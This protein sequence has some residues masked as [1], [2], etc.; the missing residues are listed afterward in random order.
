[1]AS[2]VITLLQLM[3]KVF[4]MLTIKNFFSNYSM[5][6]KIAF[7]ITVLFFF[8]FITFQALVFFGFFDI[9][10]LNVIHNHRTKIN[11]LFLFTLLFI[12]FCFIN[13]L[14]KWFINPL[15]NLNKEI[16]E[17]TN[18]FNNENIH[19]NN[20]TDTFKYCSDII[21][22]VNKK[23]SQVDFETSKLTKEKQTLMSH[24]QLT[25]S[26]FNNSQ[27]IIIIID[28]NGIITRVNPTF[29]KL[30]GVKYENLL[31]QPLIKFINKVAYKNIKASLTHELNRCHHWQGEFTI[32]H[33]TNNKNIP[34]YVK[35]NK[36][37]DNKN[38][39]IQYSIVATDLTTIKEID[40]LIYINH[41]DSLT[42]LPNRVALTNRLNDELNSQRTQCHKFAVVFI[43][44]DN[45]KKINDNYGHQM[46]DKVLKITAYK[47]RNAIKKTDMVARLSGD[48]FI[49]IINPATTQT[50]VIQT[51]ERILNVLQ[52]PIIINK[53]H[54]AMSA[55]LGCYYTHPKQHQTIEDILS[56]ADIAMYKAK[57]TGKGRIVECN[58]F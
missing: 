52:Q 33:L 8:I 38:K 35:I 30:I 43:D 39:H 3:S 51:C 41:H 22:K 56:Q 42:D 14:N 1:M 36:F 57:M 4:L 10:T 34:L 27:D 23:D 54:I 12:L 13:I 17:K 16:N 53:Q 29:C 48:E 5:Y 20:I 45:F 24:N 37:I 49:A 7:Q 50:D 55:S 18:I 26:I 6:K 2:V 40:R 47:L 25:S 11:I 46:G 58:S 19:E 44:L 9:D 21:D 32:Q 28:N 15:M 31:H